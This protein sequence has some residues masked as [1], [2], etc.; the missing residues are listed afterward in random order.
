MEPDCK[1]EKISLIKLIKKFK[2]FLFHLIK[3]K[4]I[5]FMS[6]SELALYDSLKKA[7]QDAQD[8]LIETDFFLCVLGNNF[9]DSC[10]DD[11]KL[12]EI[13]VKFEAKDNQNQNDN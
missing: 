4:K 2:E 5:E 10:V 7:Y 1:K 3:D 6:E 11:N 13:I 8:K 12:N 9:D